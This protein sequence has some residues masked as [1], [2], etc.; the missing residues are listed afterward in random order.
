MWF[1]NLVS[2]KWWDDLWLKEGFARFITAYAMDKMETDRE[3]G[4]HMLYLVKRGYLG[5]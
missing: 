4:A 2:L 3:P 1:G 5:G